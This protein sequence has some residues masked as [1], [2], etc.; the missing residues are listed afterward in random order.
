MQAGMV[1]HKSSIHDS[2]GRD[3]RRFSLIFDSDEELPNQPICDTW[4]WRSAAFSP[5]R[6]SLDL[7]PIL[8]KMKQATA[9]TH[10]SHA[11]GRIWCNETVHS[12]LTQCMRRFGMVVLPP[13]HS[14]HF[15]ATVGGATSGFGRGSGRQGRGGRAC[16]PGPGLEAEARQVA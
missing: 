2:A 15:D 4:A 12:H 16:R 10:D 1:P 7:L 13:A 5:L 3:C 14:G 9:V 8:D 6:T 11:K